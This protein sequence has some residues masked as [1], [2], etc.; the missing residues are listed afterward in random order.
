[1]LVFFRLQFQVEAF[2]GGVKSCKTIKEK[3]IGFRD[4]QL[5]LRIGISGSVSGCG[6]SNGT[7]ESRL[8]EVMEETRA[9]GA[10]KLHS[11]IK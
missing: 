2:G 9:W 11:R 8:S 1:M 5:P 6:I 10:L 7:Q 3:T 4:S